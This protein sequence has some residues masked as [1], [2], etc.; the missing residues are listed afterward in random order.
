MNFKF[1]L[2]LLILAA[3]MSSCETKIE[4]GSD[5]IQLMKREF[6]NTYLKHFTCNVL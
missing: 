2:I 6:N 3:M 1:G 4:S 5:V